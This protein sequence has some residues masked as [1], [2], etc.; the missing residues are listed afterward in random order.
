M[1]VL[2]TPTVRKHCTHTHPDGRVL[3]RPEAILPDTL[4]RPL[5]YSHDVE[6]EDLDNDEDDNIDDDN[7]NMGLNKHSSAVCVQTSGSQ[8]KL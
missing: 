4:T 6:D 1:D 2:R 5:T 7:D 3:R 8:G